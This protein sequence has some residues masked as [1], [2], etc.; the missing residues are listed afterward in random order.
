MAVVDVDV[1]AVVEVL[2]VLEGSV[3]CEPQPERAAP[4]KL[5]RR[6]A[7]SKSPA[8]DRPQGLTA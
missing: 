5:D 8:P 4:S 3:G 6:T 2:A 7:D 1:V